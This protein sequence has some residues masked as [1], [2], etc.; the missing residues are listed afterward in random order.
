M[1]VTAGTCQVKL[2]GQ[3]T[4]ST[5]GAGTAFDVPAKSGFDIRVDAGITEYVCSF[6]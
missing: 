6:R 2:D 4:F 1:E 3:A 5:Y